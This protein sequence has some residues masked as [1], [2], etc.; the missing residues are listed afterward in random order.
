VSL[1][2]DVVTVR[3]G[4]AQCAASCGARRVHT[5]ATLL[6][7]MKAQTP[8]F[9]RADFDT[10]Y[11]RAAASGEYLRGFAA[12]DRVEG[13]FASVCTDRPVMLAGLIDV[14]SGSTSFRVTARGASLLGITNEAVET[15][16]P[17][18][19]FTVR[20]DATIHVAPARRYDRFQVARVADLIALVNDEYRYGSHPLADARQF[21]ED[22]HGEGAG[23]S[24]G[25]TVD[26]GLPPTLAKAIQRWPAKARKW[27]WTRAV[28][29]AGERRGHFETLAGIT[30]DARVGDRT[31]G[32]N[33]GPHQ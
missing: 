4:H 26:H 12:W 6:A 14:D 11:V 10:D 23:L 13:A 33:G 25:K 19:D 15:T 21:A 7:R 3:R 31:A 1:R 20:S 17:I 27:K 22:F 2:S 32:A 8:D 9:L 16:E 5:F 29:V 30:Q 18:E 28:I 24:G